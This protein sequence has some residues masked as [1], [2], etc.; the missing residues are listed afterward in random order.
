MPGDMQRVTGGAREAVTLG[1]LWRLAGPTAASRAGILAMAL[2]DIMMLGRA[3]AGE[4]AASALGISL[5]LPILVGGIGLI[6]GVLVLSAQALG[7]GEAEAARA[8]LRQGLPWALLLGIAGAAICALSPLWLRLLGHTPELVSAAGAVG[9][10]IAPGAPGALIFL[11]CAYSL[12]AAERPLPV[13]LTMLGANLLNVLLNW[14]LIFGNLGFPELGAVGAAWATTI[15]RW[16]MAAS[17]IIVI[18][19]LD[20]LGMRSARDG[21][22]GRFWGPGGWRAAARM[23]ALGAAAGASALIESSFFAVLTQLAGYLGA[24]ALA[25]MALITNFETLVFMLSLGLASAT[26]VLVGGAFGRGDLAGA[27]RGL[28]LGMLSSL[29]VTATAAALALLAPEAIAHVYTT[30]AA[31]I[32]A[33]AGLF[34]WLGPMLMFDGL[35]L[36]AGMSVRALGDSWAA[37][38]RYAVAFWLVGLPAAAALA[39]GVPSLDLPAIGAHGL[40]AGAFIGAL[41]SFVLQGRRFQALSAAAESRRDAAF[42]PLA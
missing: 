19:S 23:R 5:F 7:R 4:V 31:L 34:P 33:A 41:T 24:T 16:S 36:V 39:F 29:A 13:A 35:Q 37:T 15:V 3:G 20:H 27:R 12:E 8:A 26:S 18:V 9:Q 30:E 2:V 11:V 40:I 42:Q 28:R 25:A 17:L 10:A 32:V 6:Q 14:V 1:R 21:R 38:A 22:G